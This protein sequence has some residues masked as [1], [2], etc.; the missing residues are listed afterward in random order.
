[1]NEAL[2]TQ[3]TVAFCRDYADQA[4]KLSCGTQEIQTLTNNKKKPNPKPNNQNQK[5]LNIKLQLF[6]KIPN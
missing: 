6:I 3:N 1:M 5:E 4:W 2:V